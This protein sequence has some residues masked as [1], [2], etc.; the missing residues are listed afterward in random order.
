MATD[1]NIK[2]TGF[3]SLL[4]GVHTGIDP[5]VLGEAYYSLG[6]NVSSRGGLIHTRP[7]FTTDAALGSGT[8]QGGGV[9]SLN[10]GDRWVYVVEGHVC[11]AVLDSVSPVID[12]GL[13]LST[14]AQCHFYQ[15]DRYMVIQD[16]TS[17]PIVLEEDPVT[18]I[19]GRKTLP[20]SPIPAG[21]VGSYVFGRIHMVPRYVPGTTDPG[22]PY[23]LSGDI[24]LPNDPGTCLAFTETDYLAEGGAVGMPLEMGYIYGM[25]A[26][27]NAATG[28]GYG[29]LMVFARNG[30]CA[31]DV[32]IYPRENWKNQPFGQVLFFGNGTV[33][34]WSIVPVN[35]DLAYRSADG[36][37]FIKH[38]ASQTG[39]NSGVLSNPS[40]SNEMQAYI[41]AEDETYLPYVSGA[42]CSDRFFMTTSGTDSR[43]FQA[44]MVLDTAKVAGLTGTQ[45]PS[46]DGIWQI[47]GKPVAQ[48]F[49]AFLNGKPTTF[50]VTQ[51]PDL[52]RLDPDAVMDGA[53]KIKSRIHTRVYNFDDLS[54]KILEYVE[55]WVSDLQHDTAVTVYYRPAGYPLWNVLDTRALKVAAGSLPQ[56]RRRLRF[57]LDNRSE[58]CDPV[59]K[60][61]LIGAQAFQFAIAWE[62]YMKIEAF[63]ATARLE[64]E[65]PQDVCDETEARTVT[66]VTDGVTL[67]NFL[68]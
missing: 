31:F 30:V 29:P 12:H 41:A 59:S 2:Q 37:R 46:Y 38:T 36:I 25:S 55:L 63:M 52:Y 42:I 11:S 48:V 35:D 16:G 9:W 44:L 58:V 33:S 39:G 34:P 28:T 62:G 1:S 23:F 65:S 60:Q 18:G 14:S 5:D 57:V 54:L 51:G 3:T 19:A 4:N 56:R 32:S 64:I 27:R 24:S 43:Y 50:V 49:N 40:Q 47:E 45:N 6:I 20:A 66:D 53:T 7:G 17:T 22:H 68:T 8:Y 21:Y 26:M 13:L 67:G 10:S 15:A 61:H